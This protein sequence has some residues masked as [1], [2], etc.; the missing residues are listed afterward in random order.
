MA[1]EPTALDA[2]VRLG[3]SA[4]TWEPKRLRPFSAVGR[5]AC[6]GRRLWLRLAVT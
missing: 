2:D 3:R 1:S 5:L 4:L 6:G